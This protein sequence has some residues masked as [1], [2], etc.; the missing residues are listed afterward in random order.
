MKKLVSRQHERGFSMVELLVALVIGLIMIA[1]L[2]QI[3]LANRQSYR[4]MEGANFMQENL[5]FAVDRIATSVRMADHWATV[6]RQKISNTASGS[7]CSAAWARDLSRGVWG[8]DGSASV[9]TAVG[10]CISAANYQ[11]N[12]D[13]ILVRYAGPDILPNAVGLTSTQWYV[14][15]GVG[16]D[17]GEIFRGSTPPAAPIPEA[18]QVFLMQYN[19]ELFWVR[20]CS[21]PGADAS[22][23]TSDDGDQ[24]DRIPTLMRSYLDSAGNWTSE[25]LAEGMEQLQ[26]EYQVMNRGWMNATAVNALTTLLPTP[27]DL[28]TG[29]R[30][31]GIMRSAQPDSGFG[32]DTRTFNLSSDTPNYSV[33][34]AAQRYMRVAYEANAVIRARV[35]PAPAI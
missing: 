3:F 7:L 21:D 34:A 9:P 5:R 32:P 24:P 33:P 16:S 23:G 10:S 25:P 1:G 22:C 14:R 2:I 35:R 20:R 28:I 30:V 13:I 31:A 6:S 15:A 12:T 29:A 26:L 27:W 18:T 4:V 19:A 11:P 8:V 17:K